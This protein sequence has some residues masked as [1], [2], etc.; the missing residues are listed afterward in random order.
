MQRINKRN[1]KPVNTFDEFTSAID[2]DSEDDI[3]S[4][5]TMLH[6]GDDKNLP[7]VKNLDADVRS[8]L[9][10][11]AQLFPELQRSVPKL[12]MI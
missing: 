3:I 12:R 11:L 2:D 4:N 9:N 8:N 6:F 5:P 10:V 7:L 1:F